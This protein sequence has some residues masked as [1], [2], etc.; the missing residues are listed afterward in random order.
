MQSNSTP[1]HP[2]LYK[3]TFWRGGWRTHSVMLLCEALTVHCMHCICSPPTVLRRC[4]D[5]CF[6][7]KIGLREAAF[8]GHTAQEGQDSGAGFPDSR[9][10]ASQPPEAGPHRESNLV[11]GHALDKFIAE[12]GVKPS[13]PNSG[14]SLHAQNIATTTSLTNL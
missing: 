11:P 1:S 5:V 9:V 10:G 13:T 4:C 2:S 14:L 6:A 7:A 8:Q 3:W 12:A